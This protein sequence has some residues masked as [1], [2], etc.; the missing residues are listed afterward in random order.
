MSSR[1]NVADVNDLLLCLFIII[2]TQCMTRFLTFP[3][4]H[5]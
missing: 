2:Y 3:R 4:D 5:V 1:E